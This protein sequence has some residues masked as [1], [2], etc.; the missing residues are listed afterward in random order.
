MIS[1]K[2]I[3]DSICY[4]TG[5]RITTFEVSPPR[6]ILS[7]LNTHR[8]F[9]RN[10]ASSR[11]IPLKSN[12]NNI[13]NNTATPVY[14]G[15]NKPG[16]VADEEISEESKIKANEIWLKARDSAIEYAIQLE[17]LGIHKQIS[18]RLIENF[19]YQKVIITSTEWI[20]FF[21]QRAHKD[22]QPEFRELAYMMLDLYNKASDIEVLYENEWHTPYVK[23]IRIDNDLYYLDTDNNFLSLEDALKI[24]VSSCAQVSYRKNDNTLE[25]AI[26]IF[27]KLNLNDVEKPKHLSPLDHQATPILVNTTKGIT[28]VDVDNEYNKWSGNL[29]GWVQYRHLYN[30]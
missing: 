28:H 5:A 21:N 12:I 15:K 11:A 14:W 29:K 16:M 20:N 7:E 10:S 4:P 27:S 26:D 30:K 18:N 19:S 25:K 1:A 6:W 2:V 17:E 13:L 3:A 22:A 8:V 9:G 24:S 23:H